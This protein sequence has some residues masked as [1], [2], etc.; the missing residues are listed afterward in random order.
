MNGILSGM[1]TGILAD[2]RQAAMLQAGLGLL[3]SSGP[4]RT[5]VGLGQAIGQAGMQGINAYNQTNQANQQQQLFQM[6]LAE[7]QREMDE[8]KKKEAALAAL[9]A[10][11]R[12]ANLGPLLDVAPAAAI[13]RAYP[14]PDNDSPFAKVNPKDFTPES[15]RKFSMTKNPSDLVAV[16]DPAKTPA[17]S[18]LAKLTRE[19][20][21]LPAQHPNRPLYDAKIKKLTEQAFRT[22][23]RTRSLNGKTNSGPTTRPM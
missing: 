13:E 12:F 11:P 2:P 23:R 20:D 15:V 6:K 17:E 21:A 10:D 5:P 14:K 3:A 16:A 18:D 7:V 8:R 1:P 4:S 9:R 22:F 19:R